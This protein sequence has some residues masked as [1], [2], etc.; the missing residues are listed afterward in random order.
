MAGNLFLR[1]SGIK[2]ECVESNHKEWIDVTHYSEGLSHSNSSGYG[3][4]GGV[5]SVSYDDFTVNCQLEKA[6]PALMAGCAGNKTYDKVEL[7][8]TKMEGT[9]S[10]NYIEITMEKV[11]VTSVNF[12]GSQN[13]IPNVSVRLAFEKI[14]TDYYV[15]LATGG[16][17][18]ISTAKWDQKENK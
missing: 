14:Q 6:I 5:G 1:I 11:L 17:G 16:R 8:A 7:H 15:Q 12:S 9:V 10:W 2:G 4:G 3:G 13:E 18:A